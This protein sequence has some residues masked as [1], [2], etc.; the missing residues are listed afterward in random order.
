MSELDAFH[1]KRFVGVLEALVE[2]LRHH[3]VEKWAAWFAADLA[4]YR[5]GQGP[6]RQVVRQRAVVEHVLL[7]FGGMSDF[8]RL[9]ITDAAGEPLPEANERL[10]F[11]AT[12]LWA[13]ARS[14][15]GVLVEE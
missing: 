2:F 11:L 7:A 13:A 8:R 9:Q 4:D 3:G 6:P 14:M 12:Q 10:E 5:A 15:Q 1:E